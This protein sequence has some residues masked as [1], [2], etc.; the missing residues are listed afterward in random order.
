MDG[1][2]I[3]MVKV[4]FKTTLDTYK[5]LEALLPMTLERKDVQEKKQGTLEFMWRMR[6]S[7]RGDYIKTLILGSFTVNEGHI[8]LEV[9]SQERAEKGK[10]LVERYGKGDITFERM[11]IESP[12]AV[13]DP[14]QKSPLE[15]EE[16]LTPEIEAHVREIMKDHWDNWLD[17]P[18]PMLGFKTPREA[19][20]TKA[21]LK[22]VEELLMHYEENKKTSKNVV[23]MDVDYLRKGLGLKA[24]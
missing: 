3:D 8:I 2:H 12:K 21:G 17:H 14:T 5:A 22:K 9:N 19:I 18:V 24:P 15:E 13:Q 16:A 1:E 20:K 23:E 11:V 7:V 10:A 6:E 4:Y